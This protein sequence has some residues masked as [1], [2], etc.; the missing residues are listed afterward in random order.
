MVVSLLGT[1]VQA[2]LW[3]TV[4][5]LALLTLVVTAQAVTR[6]ATAILGRRRPAEA[7]RVPVARTPQLVR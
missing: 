1:L 4:V 3:V 6:R 7:V 5:S 2:W